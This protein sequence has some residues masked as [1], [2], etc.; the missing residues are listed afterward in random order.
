MY[1]NTYKLNNIREV[2]LQKQ[3]AVIRYVLVSAYLYAS[4]NDDSSP[5]IC[6]NFYMV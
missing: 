4:N 6:G 3:T 2:L 5:Y 1:L